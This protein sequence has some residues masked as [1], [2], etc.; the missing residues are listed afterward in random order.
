MFAPKILLNFTRRFSQAKS[1]Q[2]IGLIHAPKQGSCGIPSWD[3]QIEIPPPPKA[4]ELPANLI[5]K[6]CMPG[7]TPGEIQTCLKG[8]KGLYCQP[9]RLKY[10]YP[11]FS[12]N[13]DFVPPANES[14][15]WWKHPPSCQEGLFADV[16]TLKTLT[17]GWDCNYDALSLWNSLFDRLN[18]KT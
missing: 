12:D 15:C 5:R 2:K 13:I 10:K 17:R 14:V 7:S 16:D 4:M 8:I 9:C 1:A 18:F 6:P 11:A 3:P